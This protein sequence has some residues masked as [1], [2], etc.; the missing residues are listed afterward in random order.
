MIVSVICHSDTYKYVVCFLLGNSPASEF[1]TPTLWN[2]QFQLHR[3]VGAPTCLWIW[4]RQSVPKRRHIK[5]RRRGI[6]QKKAYNIQI[7]VK[8]WNQ[9]YVQIC[10]INFRLVV[11]VVFFL[12]GD[13]PASEF[14]VPTFRTLCLF[15]LHRSCEQGELF[16]FTRIMKMEQSVPKRRHIQFRHRGITQ[17]KEY[18]IFNKFSCI[19]IKVNITIHVKNR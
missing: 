6:T 13:S 1:Y 8:V 5:F 19:L 18:N 11:N 4:K 3:Q 12:L 7:T 15:H 17:K 10:L 2:T 16:L 9:E 14:Y